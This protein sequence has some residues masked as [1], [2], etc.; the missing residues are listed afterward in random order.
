MPTLR[1]PASI[2]TNSTTCPNPEPRST[3]TSSFESAL[4]LIRWRIWRTGVGL[5]EHHL[6]VRVGARITRLTEL[7]NTAHYLI[8]VV[9]AEAGTWACC[10]VPSYGNLNPVKQCL[11]RSATHNLGTDGFV[12]VGIGRLHPGLDCFC[13]VVNPGFCIAH[14][15]FC[16]E[17]SES[18]IELVQCIEALPHSRRLHKGGIGVQ[19]GKQVLQIPIRHSIPSW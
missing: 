7:E 5:I 10:F 13:R 4:A 8:T 19:A 3:K 18:G 6:G 1:T 11:G 9:I 12:N 15:L 14:E 17:N 16:M 2:D